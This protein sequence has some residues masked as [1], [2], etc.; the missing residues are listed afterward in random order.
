M[1]LVEK[2]IFIH[3]ENFMH[4]TSDLLLVWSIFQIGLCGKELMN[5]WAL[6]SNP[7]LWEIFSLVDRQESLHFY[8]LVLSTLSCKASAGLVS[9]SHF[10]HEIKHNTHDLRICV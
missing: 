4:S 6:M 8:F 5:L 3:L 10:S 2:M 7:Y 9:L 1:E